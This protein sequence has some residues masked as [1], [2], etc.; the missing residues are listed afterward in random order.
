MFDVDWQALFGFEK[1]LLELFVR[2]TVMYWFLFLIF[3][4]V[5]RR[6]VGAIGIADV[7]VVVIIAD[8]AQ[9]GMSGD[10]QSITEG[11]VLIGTLILWNVVM[12]WAGFHSKRFERFAEPQPL[13]LIRDGKLLVDNLKQEWL[14]REEL[15]SK[16]RQ[17]GIERPDEVRWAYMESDGQISV[18]KYSEDEGDTQRS[19][20][21]QGGGAV[22]AAGGK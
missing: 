16:L 11:F 1:S 14:T 6:D 18:R 13:P 4:F 5:L 22:R 7:L 3:R 19:G 2:G 15:M 10:Y 8:A 17:Q 20:G 9:N 12:D 21:S